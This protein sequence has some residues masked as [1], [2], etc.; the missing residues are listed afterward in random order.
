VTKT[1]YEEFT[2]HNDFPLVSCC[3]TSP[4]PTSD[5]YLSANSR[6][7][8]RSGHSSKSRRLNVND[9]ISTDFYSFESTSENY[10][11]A[12][13]DE[14]RPYFLRQLASVSVYEG[15][16][17]ILECRVGG[18]PEPAVKWYRWDNSVIHDSPDFIYLKEANQTYKLVIRVGSL[19]RLLPRINKRRN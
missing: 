7:S 15:D 9:I 2:A 13:D 18:N 3:S 1:R 6:L 14:A 5:N 11:T 12:D 19:G 4:Q 17:A 16:S 10:Q 8:R